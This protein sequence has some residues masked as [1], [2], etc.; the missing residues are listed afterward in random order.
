MG[1]SHEIPW[2]IMQFDFGL[3]LRSAYIWKA[4][5]DVK[6]AEYGDAYC[7]DVSFGVTLGVDTRDV[8]RLQGISLVMFDRL[9]A[10]E[11]IQLQQEHEQT[12][13]FYQINKEQMEL[14]RKN[15]EEQNLSLRDEITDL[16]K[17]FD[18]VRR[19]TG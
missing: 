8:T 9:L 3:H 4:L 18:E 2:A 13:T 11:I 17:E 16:Q 1:E 10:A 19:F 14:C 6:E 15:F 7:Q 5:R 12:S